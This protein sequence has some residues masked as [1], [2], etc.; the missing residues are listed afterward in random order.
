MPQR[1]MGRKVAGL[2]LNILLPGVGTFVLGGLM[3][4]GIVQVVLL[5]VGDIMRFSGGLANLGNAVV[6]GDW[7]WAFVLS[8]RAFS[9]R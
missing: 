5:I 2:I 7:I 3:T 6:L 8:I 9:N 1:T 4:V